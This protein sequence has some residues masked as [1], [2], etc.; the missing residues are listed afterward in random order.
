MSLLLTNYL[1]NNMKNV[2]MKSFLVSDI[3]MK[4]SY[5]ILK[6]IKDNRGKILN[7]T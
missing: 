4:C 5:F 1:N 3:E 6:E 7:Q 2:K